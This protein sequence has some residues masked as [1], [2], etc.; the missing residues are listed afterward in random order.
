MAFIFYNPNPE[1]NLVGDCVIRAVSIVTG[2]D[3]DST[4]LDLMKLGYEL[5]DW[6]D[7]NWVWGRYLY[8]HGFRSY[9]IN[10]YTKRRYTVKD[11]CEDCPNCK[12]VLATGTHVVA[13]D[14]GNYYD[15]WDSGNEV[16]VYYWRKE[17]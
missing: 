2:Q 11:F 14:N 17:N 6:P 8:E 5:K 9:T 12:G 7:A 10:E 16:P 4:F 1:S 15:T 3:W 13:I